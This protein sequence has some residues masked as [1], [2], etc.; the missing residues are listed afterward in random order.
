MRAANH[1]ATSGKLPIIASVIL[2]Y[3]NV[4]VRPGQLSALAALPTVVCIAV[5]GILV[6]APWRIHPLSP[7]FLLL[8]LIPMACLGLAWAKHS[9]LDQ[10][11]SLI[12]RGP[13]IA[14]YLKVLSCYAFWTLCLL[15]WPAPVI[16][17]A[18]FV[19]Y[20]IVGGGDAFSNVVSFLPI[21]WLCLIVVGVIPFAR[22]FLSLPL[23]AID[24][25]SSPLA[26]WRLGSNIRWR[27]GSALFL[28]AI[29]FLAVTILCV[30]LL[31][32][33]AEWAMHAAF[34]DRAFHDTI[35]VRYGLAFPISF[36]IVIPIGSVIG[37]TL[38]AEFL[39]IAFRESDSWNGPQGDILERFD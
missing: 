18:V 8:L 10:P 20:A 27:L 2:A 5:G 30:G 19:A 17:L 3:R 15:I 1:T 35:Y 24:R 37:T 28:V 26:A 13:W 9:V 11:P 21:S 31:I 23:I 29:T 7:L 34:L 32:A 33:A 4:F 14:A 12:M 36:G 25:P 16:L 6:V 39:V 22:L 38:F